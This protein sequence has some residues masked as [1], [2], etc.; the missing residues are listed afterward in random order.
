M[1]TR[2]ID[3]GL[4]DPPIHAH[5]LSMDET[6]LNQLADGIRRQGLINAIQLIEAN[7][8]YTI[9]AGHRRYLA[10]KMI[11]MHQI[12]ADILHAD[13]Q[14]APSEIQFAENFL[15]VDLSPIEEARALAVELDRS[16]MT[17]LQL[18]VAVQ[19]TVDW[20]E[21]R[22][23]LLDLPDDLG[24]LVHNRTLAIASALLLARVT[25]AQ[26]RQ[27]LTDYCTNSGASAST[28][29]SWV[30]QWEM[31]QVQRPGQPYTLPIAAEAGD[32]PVISLPCFG[33][34]TPH[35]YGTMQITRYCKQCYDTMQRAAA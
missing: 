11:R 13:S 28:I 3:I 30:G 22:L 27:H 5:R 32:R 6:G 34:R 7:G 14:V 20:V 23:A 4:I 29:R 17:P 31:D 19:R 9:V 33:C 12:R 21:G 26:H 35:D 15:R 2:E 24:P 16:T 18:S 1:D 10:C 25:D 8:R